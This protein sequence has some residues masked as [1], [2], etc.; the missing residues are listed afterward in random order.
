MSGHHVRLNRKPDC[1]RAALEIPDVFTSGGGGLRSRWFAV[2]DDCVLCL[3][4]RDDMKAFLQRHASR[5]D[6][7]ALATLLES[8]Q[9]EGRIAHIY[10]ADGSLER[11]ID[12]ASDHL[13]E[14]MGLAA[15]VLVDDEVEFFSWRVVL[16]DALEV[17]RVERWTLRLRS[18]DGPQ[19]ITT[20]LPGVL[21]FR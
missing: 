3:D 17:V 14:T 20:T 6:A 11:L 21:H 13:R 9:G 2:F 7:T 1:A 15:P 19:W 18:P 8:C 10:L 4:R 16:Q 12:E 5:E